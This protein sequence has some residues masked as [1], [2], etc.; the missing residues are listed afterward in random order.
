MTRLVFIDK[1]MKVAWLPSCLEMLLLPFRVSL[2]LPSTFA[3]VSLP[4]PLLLVLLLLLTNSE[5]CISCSRC[6]GS[7]ASF[8]SRDAA[9][10]FARVTLP[11]PSTFARVTLPQPLLHDLV[12]LLTNI[13]CS[14]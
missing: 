1:A 13:E 8:L 11:L 2:P 14:F 6:A 4:L 5:C 12:L 3:R 9:S 7:L 10:T